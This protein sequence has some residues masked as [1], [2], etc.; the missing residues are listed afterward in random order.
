M[1]GSAPRTGTGINRLAG[2]PSAS[3]IEALAASSPLPEDFAFGVSMA[4][5]QNEGGY[6]GRAEPKNNFYDWEDT[7]KVEVSGAATNFWSDPEAHLDRAAAMSCNAF[8]LSVDWAR[9]QPSADTGRSEPPDFDTTALDAYASIMAACRT[10]GLEPLVTLHHFTQPRWVGLDAWTRR[11]TVDLFIDY[12][13]ETVTGIN[14]R[15][16]AGGGEPLKNYITI[17]EPNGPGPGG[18][19]VGMF[20]PGKFGDIKGA[21]GATDNLLAAHVRAYNKIHD[22][23][24]EHGWRRP[25]VTTNTFVNW[26]WA[27]E[28]LIPDLLLARENGVEP[29]GLD[30]YF[31][32]SRRKMRELRDEDPNPPERWR[33]LLEKGMDKVT[34][35]IG[36][37][38]FPHAIEEIWSAERASSLDLIGIDYYDPYF[39]RGVRMPGRK[40]AGGTRWSPVADFWEQV[41]N[42]PGLAIVARVAMI[43]AGGKDVVIAENGIASQTRTNLSFGRP[44]GITRADYIRR[45]LAQLLVAR[46]AGVPLTGYYQWTLV[47]NYEWGSYEPCFGIHG[48]DRSSGSPIITDEDAMACDSAGAYREAIEAMT[49]GDPELIAQ[50][51]S[52]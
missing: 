24:E 34:D 23:Y 40:Q 22:I 44:D 41:V 36:P 25:T 26:T 27:M 42:P 32:E 8:R 30:P 49:S 43:N 20:P 39:S 2:E 29:N 21:I 31:V 10:R 14:T 45:H 4:A 13:D 16:V 47:D 17:N 19:L 28:R 1:S 48:I 38:H 50:V 52:Q 18:Y 3:E 5:F 35:N 9:I 6:N 37:R 7:S 33:M 15:L 11:S 51:L 46:A 12:V